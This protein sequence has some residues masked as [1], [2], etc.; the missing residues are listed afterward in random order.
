MDETKC[1][2]STPKPKLSQPQMTHQLAAL[3]WKTPFPEPLSFFLEVLGCSLVSLLKSPVPGGSEIQPEGSGLSK[4][5]V[6]DP[7]LRYLYPLPP[8]GYPLLSC[9]KQ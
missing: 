5:T 9:A 4:V 8:N 1:L 7:D 2:K 3:D 6:A